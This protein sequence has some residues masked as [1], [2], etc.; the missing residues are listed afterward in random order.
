MVSF[1]IE[2]TELSKG[3]TESLLPVKPYGYYR[4]FVHPMPGI[5]GPGAMRIV[6]GQSGK[7]WFTFDHYKSFIPIR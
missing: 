1:L 4:E 3:Q 2:M 7:M 6:L 5:S